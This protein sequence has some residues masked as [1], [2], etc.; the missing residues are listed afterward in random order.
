MTHLKEELVKKSNKI[1]ALEQERDQ[2][3]EELSRLKSGSTAKNQSRGKLSEQF[4]EEFQDEEENQETP[5]RSFE[6]KSSQTL[7]GSECTEIFCKNLSWSTDENTLGEFFSRY[8]AINKVKI[9]YDKIS[10]RSKGCAFIEF[11]TREQAQ[12]AIDEA[13]DLEYEGRS[14]QIN[15]A[16]QKPERREQS[17]YG[18]RESSFGESD[19]RQFRESR[20]KHTAFVGNLGFNTNEETIRSFF[21][22]CGEIVSLRLGQNEEGRQKGYCHIDFESAE[23]LELALRKNGMELDGRGLRVD[24]GVPRGDRSDRGGYRGDRGDRGDFRG[25]R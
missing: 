16:D 4:S 11:A 7:S 12:K 14:L 2:Y 17:P 19:F 9:L 6:R 3:K 22:D 1:T 25:Y 21:Q 23:G 15:F 13:N 8:G 5:R 18:E 24:R 10:G 20:K